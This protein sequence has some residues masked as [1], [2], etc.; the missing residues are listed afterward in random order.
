MP[1]ADNKPVA[2]KKQEAKA[3]TG[4]ATAPETVGKNLRVAAFF[5]K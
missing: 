3:V 5:E 2:P 4:A 1:C